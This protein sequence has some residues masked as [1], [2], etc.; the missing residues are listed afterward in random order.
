MAKTRTRTRTR[1]RLT[2]RDMLSRSTRTVEMSK[3][4]RRQTAYRLVGCSLT[5]LILSWESW[6]SLIGFPHSN[7]SFLA[8][9]AFEKGKRKEIR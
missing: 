1:T 3:G 7:T 8:S 9:Q 2:E 4:K 5:Q 6:F